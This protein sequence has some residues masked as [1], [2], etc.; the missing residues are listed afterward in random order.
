MYV[1]RGSQWGNQFRIHPEAEPVSA[2]RVA[3][4]LF[5]DDVGHWDPVELRHWLAPL[6]G[7]DFACWC[8]TCPAHADGLPLGVA[9]PDCPP[10]HA[11]TLLT[12]A[13]A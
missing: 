11:D 6:R 4:E 3:V 12:L 8:G 1:G 2:A 7:H 10:C 5:R 13:N 9:C